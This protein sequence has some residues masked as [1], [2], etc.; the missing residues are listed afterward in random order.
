MK[1]IEKYLQKQKSKSRKKLNVAQSAVRTWKR[2][3]STDCEN[4]QRR[5]RNSE[6]DE[7]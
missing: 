5:N 4:E 1:G 2:T 3:E 6:M 7:S